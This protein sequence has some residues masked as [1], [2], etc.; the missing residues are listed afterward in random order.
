MNENERCLV[1][2]SP[3]GEIEA[4][5]RIWTTKEAISKA[6][7]IG[8]AESWERVTVKDIG[9]SESIMEI[10]NKDHAAFHDAIDNHLFTIINME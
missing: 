5:V 6:L 9:V 8:L 4:S 2:G 3:L 1:K 7:G 10:N